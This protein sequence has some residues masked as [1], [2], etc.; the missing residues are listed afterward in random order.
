M[1]VAIG[2]SQESYDGKDFNTTWINNN[3]GPTFS[4]PPN[5]LRTK[6]N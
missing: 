3:L 1:V 6:L 5:S 2:V 4:I